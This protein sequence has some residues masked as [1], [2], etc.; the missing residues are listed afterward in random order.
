[1]RAEFRPGDLLVANLKWDQGL[2]NVPLEHMCI[3]F[4]MPM[5]PPA[6]TALATQSN[7][8][9]RMDQLI[10]ALKNLEPELR[11]K[12]SDIL[13]VQARKNM[14]EQGKGDEAKKKS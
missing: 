2:K 4:P 5:I 7:F 6:G 8:V 14:N 9:L 13:R 12:L 10:L 1:M 11:W 3:T